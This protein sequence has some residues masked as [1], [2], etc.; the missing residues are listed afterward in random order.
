MLRLIWD[1]GTPACLPR[2]ARNEIA[3]S[4]LRIMDLESENDRLRRGIGTAASR[5]YRLINSESL[6]CAWCEAEVNGYLY[7]ERD[8]RAFHERCD[9]KASAISSR[10]DA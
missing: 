6:R 4:R 1:N 8:G 9:F 7:V 2:W 5:R 3:S 10:S